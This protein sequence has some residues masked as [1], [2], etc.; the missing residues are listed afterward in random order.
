MLG[1]WRVKARY[2]VQSSSVL[3]AAEHIAMHLESSR[4]VV[5]EWSRQCC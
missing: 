4:H 2:S 3:L 1:G 5:Y